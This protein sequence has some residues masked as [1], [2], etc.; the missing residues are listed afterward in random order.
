MSEYHDA[1]NVINPE[2]ADHHVVT[3]FQYM[4][5][6]GTLLIFTGITV[7][8]AFLDLGVLNPVVALGIASFKAVIVIL[9]FMHV[10]YQS[11]LVKMTIGAGFF[12]FLV[13]ITM[14]L[15]DYMSRAWGLW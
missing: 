15:T 3:P 6:F 2:H 5:V 1:A 8:A 9:F 13:L 7:G 12:T 11:K 14:T 4:L 10:K